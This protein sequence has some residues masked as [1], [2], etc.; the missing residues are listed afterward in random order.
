M[1][2]APLVNAVIVILMSWSFQVIVRYNMQRER[3]SRQ[4]IESITVESLPVHKVFI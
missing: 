1:L 3:E 4:L 2:S